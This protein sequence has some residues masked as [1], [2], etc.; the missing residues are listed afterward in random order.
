M[1]SS[2]LS[3][4]AFV[5]F[6]LGRRAVLPGFFFCSVFAILFASFCSNCFSVKGIFFIA[7]FLA[8]LFLTTAFF[9]TDF[10]TTVFLRVSVFVAAFFTTAF[11][12]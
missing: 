7:T 5:A 6:F 4:C 2:K 3:V 8:A 9:V 10:F 12:L 11:F 1:A